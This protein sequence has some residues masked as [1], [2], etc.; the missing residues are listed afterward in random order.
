M[1]EQITSK[2]EAGRVPPHSDEAERAV[3]GAL[4]LDGGRIPE[5][6]EELVADDFFSPRHRTLFGVLVELAAEN[7]PIDFVSVSGALNSTGRMTSAG[8]Y[9]ALVEL[10]ECVTTTAHLQHHVRLVEQASTLRRLAHEAT[11]IVSETFRTKLGGE[12]VEELLDASEHR[13]YH[14]ARRAERTQAEPLRNLLGEAFEDITA[15][16]HRGNMSGLETPFFE[17]N[18]ITGGLN[19]G[20]MIILAA[21][22][23]MGKTA[24][25]LNMLEHAA[26]SR[27]EGFDQPPRVLLF[28]L[29]MGKQQIAKRMIFSRA[30][31]A[32]WKLKGDRIPEEDYLLLG[33]AV[34]E[35]SQASLY[36]DDTPDMSVMG[37]RARARRIKARDGLDLIVVD[38]LQLMHSPRAE[39]RQVEISSISR[40]LK[41]LARELEVPV[42]A[43]AQLS[44]QVELRDPP[45]PQLADLRESGSLEQDADI[46]MLLTRLERYPKYADNPDYKNRAELIIAKHRNGAT[47]RIHLQFFG[48]YMRFENPTVGVSEAIYADSETLS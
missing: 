2:A 17:L 5:V 31:V 45:I 29:E 18:N 1:S 33:E 30:R 13:I 8:G 16:A 44:R 37:M 10:A 40:S 23:S 38:Y 48:E 20:D 14:V 22:P 36:I 41:Q 21:R 34:N 11:A 35:L 19:K 3:L 12:E 9:E 46:V 26:L 4:L 6:A 15:R 32:A 25:A 43:L 7:V 28:S 47:G 27:P 39:S 24:L 42:I